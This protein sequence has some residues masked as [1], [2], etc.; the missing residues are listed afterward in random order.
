MLFHAP[1]CVH[2]CMHERDM[3]S[4]LHLHKVKVHPLNVL[5]FLVLF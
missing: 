3:T 2:A 1:I 5:D 4:T